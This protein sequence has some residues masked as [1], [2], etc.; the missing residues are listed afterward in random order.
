MVDMSI[1]YDTP[2]FRRDILRTVALHNGESGQ[3]TRKSLEAWYGG[4]VEVNHGRLYPNL[5]ALIGG[6]L[7][8]KGTIDRRTNSYTVAREGYDL[9]VALLERDREATAALEDQF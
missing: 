5:D 2:G 7:V 4:D 3:A 6:G 8:E 9:L 1:L